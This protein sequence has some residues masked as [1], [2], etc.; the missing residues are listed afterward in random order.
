MRVDRSTKPDVRSVLCYFLNNGHNHPLFAVKVI[1]ASTGGICYSNDMAWTVPRTPMLPSPAPAIAGGSVY[2]ATPV[3]P[4]FNTTATCRHL[5]RF[6]RQSPLPPPLQPPPPPLPPSQSSSLPPAVTLP[7]PH[8]EPQRISGRTRT[9]ALSISPSMMPTFGHMLFY[10]F[11]FR[12]IRKATVLLTS[13]CTHVGKIERSERYKLKTFIVPQNVSQHR[14]VFIRTSN[15]RDGCVFVRVFLRLCIPAF[16]LGYLSDI[17]DFFIVYLLH[18]Y[19][20]MLKGL[21]WVSYWLTFCRWSNEL[22]P[23]EFLNK[24]RRRQTM[25]FSGSWVQIP[26]SVHNNNLFQTFPH[27]RT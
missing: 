17:L 25:F 27:G 20:V 11:V 16:R 22:I 15:R 10:F 2:A 12:N 21:V 26:P 13:V 8:M 14:P 5:H 7:R 4:V 3:T 19:T 6:G 1:K 18:S 24:W 23:L 9:S